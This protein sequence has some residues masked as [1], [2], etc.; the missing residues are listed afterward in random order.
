MTH[1]AL[2]WFRSSLRDPS[3]IA[4]Y[5]LSLQIFIFGWQGW[6]LRRHAITLEHHQEIAE[7]QASTA[8]LIGQAMNQ[9]MTLMSDLLKFQ[10]LLETQ[11]ERKIVF[12]LF[13]QLLT[14]VYSL[15]AKLTVVQYTSH[16]EV[17]QITDCW[18]RMDNNA[19]V[20][21]MALK[22]CE[23]LS[24]DEVRHIS[25]YLDDVGQLKQTNAGNR[26]DYHQLMSFNARHDDILTIVAKDRKEAIATITSV[27]EETF[28]S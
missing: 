9:Q 12:D 4:A 28:E 24:D 11:S 13:T 23:Y 22:S 20:C 10:K 15:T 16:Q 25:A 14:S 27:A 2:V 1:L 17:E 3:W 21:R 6:I 5:A 8:D 18:T 26:A 7:E 19:T